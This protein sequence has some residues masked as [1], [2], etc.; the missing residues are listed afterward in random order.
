MQ[1][2]AR[3]YVRPAQSDVSTEHSQYEGRPN[4]QALHDFF[5]QFDTS[6]ASHSAVEKLLL[7]YSSS[8]TGIADLR[9]ALEQEYGSAPELYY[10]MSHE[11]CFGETIENAKAKTKTNKPK[12]SM[13]GALGAISTSL[14]KRATKEV[15]VVSAAAAASAAAVVASEAVASAVGAAVITAMLVSTCAGGGLA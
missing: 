10:D 4:Q 7:K 15:D 8:R 9:S 3:K 2:I 13:N 14:Q 6:K 12:S 11:V 1:G 5:E